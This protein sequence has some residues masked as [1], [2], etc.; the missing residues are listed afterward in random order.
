MPMEKSQRPLSPHLQIYRPQLTS[1]LSITHRATGIALAFGTLLLVYWLLAAASG[2]DAYA[3][4]QALLG[5]WIGRIVLLG[6]SFALFFHLCNGIRH[7]FWDAG[8]GFELKTA[9]AS[10]NAV[11]IVSILLTLMAWAMAYA[12]RGGA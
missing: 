6:F 4:A 7:L 9:Y 2:A 1:V 8:L 11:I 3:S 10:G 5:S 12:M